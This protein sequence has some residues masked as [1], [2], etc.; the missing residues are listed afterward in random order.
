MGDEMK[1]NR[2]EEIEIESI[3]I[4]EQEKSLGG[5]KKRE[6][7]IGGLLEMKRGKASDLDVTAVQLYKYLSDS[8]TEWLL[9]I[10]NRCMEIG[11]VSHG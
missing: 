8:I 10:Y 1:G 3:E 5:R 9:T 2:N 6:E 11:S 7:V 4:E